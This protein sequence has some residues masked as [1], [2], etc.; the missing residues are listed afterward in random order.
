MTLVWLLM[1][2]KHIKKP[3]TYISLFLLRLIRSTSTSSDPSRCCFAVEAHCPFFWLLEQQLRCSG[4][5]CCTSLLQGVLSSERPCGAAVLTAGTSLPVWWL[6]AIFS[7]SSPRRCLEA[8]SGGREMLELCKC[9]QAG[10]TPGVG[11]GWQMS[12]TACSFSGGVGKHHPK[13]TE[14]GSHLVAGWH[15]KPYLH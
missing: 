14:L 1:L 8:P 15:S 4:N 12:C 10:T 11:V 13:Q 2:Q 7:S 3:I 5:Y 6:C 9:L